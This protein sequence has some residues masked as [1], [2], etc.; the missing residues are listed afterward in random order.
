MNYKERKEIFENINILVKSEHEEIFKIIR[1]HKITYT[2][3]SNG[4]F[5]DL[6][7]VSDDALQQIKEYI[8]FCLKT[9]Q[10]HESRLKDLESIRIQN[11]IYIK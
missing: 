4:I 5:F 9:R 11:E 2:E 3:N 1:K 7:T 6:N 10:E 8:V